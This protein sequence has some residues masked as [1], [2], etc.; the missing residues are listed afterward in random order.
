MKVL[1]AESQRSHGHREPVHGDKEAPSTVGM[2]GAGH[3]KNN[4][5]KK[6]NGRGWKK[7]EGR[8]GT[9]GGSGLGSSSTDKEAPNGTNGPCQGV[10]QERGLSQ[11]RPPTSQPG[12]APEMQAVRPRPCWQGWGSH[13]PSITSHSLYNA[14][15]FIPNSEQTKTPRLREG[16]PHMAEQ[17]VLLTSRSPAMSLFIMTVGE[18]ITVEIPGEG[19]LFANLHRGSIWMSGGE[20]EIEQCIQGDQVGEKWRGALNTGAPAGGDPLLPPWEP[21]LHSS[22]KTSPCPLGPRHVNPR[23]SSAS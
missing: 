5:R 4:Q 18:Q 10:L 8:P 21:A 7:G 23:P 14:W 9:G 15:V 13:W 2:E 11:L 17:G 6:L 12:P 1:G 20:S 22:R 19:A 16:P 3:S